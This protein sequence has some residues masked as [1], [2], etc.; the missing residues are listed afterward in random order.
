ML[1]IG[2]VQVFHDPMVA[3][4]NDTQELSKTHEVVSKAKTELWHRILTH[5][6]LPGGI[7][8]SNI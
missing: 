5:Y 7:L 2:V 6:P 4:T 1:E 3:G 8:H